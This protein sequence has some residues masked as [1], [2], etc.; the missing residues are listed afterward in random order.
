MRQ[1]RRAAAVAVVAVW[2]APS[3]SAALQQAQLQ[4]KDEIPVFYNQGIARIRGGWIL[5]GTLSPIPNT[6]VIVH[7]D[8][9]FNVLQRN[10]AAIPSD[11]RSRGYVHIGDI[12]VVGNVIYAPF[13]QPDYSLGHQV[14]ARYDTRTL[15][16]LDAV[17][18]PQHENSFVVVD[19]KTRTAYSMDH[20]DGDEL[21]RYDVAHAWKPLRPLKLSMLLEH[22]QGASIAQGAIW[23]ST[24]DAHNDIYRVNMKTGHVDLVAQIVDPP[25][26]GEGIAVVPLPS[27]LLHAT[28]LDPDQTKV[29]VEHFAAPRRGKSRP[30][31]TTS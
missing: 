16:F 5:S 14:T 7:T 11:W 25:G 9:Q 4:S 18:L 17:E 10:E 2:F 27:G 1:W 28:V 30:T 13:E 19:A 26:E 29:W 31:T 6:D 8:E 12:D 15:K 23:I 22:T 21:L 24:S 20:F 3:A